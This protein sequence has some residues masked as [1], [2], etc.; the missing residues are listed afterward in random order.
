MKACHLV[1]QFW[2]DF[3]AVAAFAPS[4]YRRVCW[5]DSPGLKALPLSVWTGPPGHITRLLGL[6]GGC[7]GSTDRGNSTPEPQSPDI[8]WAGQSRKVHTGSDCGWQNKQ[9][10]NRD[11]EWE[12]DQHFWERFCQG[13]SVPPLGLGCLRSPHRAGTLRG[14]WNG[15]SA[16]STHRG[17][18]GAARGLPRYHGGINTTNFVVRRA[19]AW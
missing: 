3:L 16:F 9:F 18:G 12:G 11:G 8:R 1:S 5:E 17:G 10:W 7:S 19:W 13:R 6:A 15:S 2:H 4:A 14:W